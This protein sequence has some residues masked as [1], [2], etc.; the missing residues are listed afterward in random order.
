[1]VPHRHQNWLHVSSTRRS[2]PIAVSLIHQP[3]LW[4]LS[5]DSPH[6]KVFQFYVLIWKAYISF[7]QYI[8]RE[9]VFKLLE[10]LGDLKLFHGLQ[11]SECS[12]LFF[13]PIS[14]QGFGLY[15]NLD[16]TSCLQGFPTRPSSAQ[17]PFS[18]SQSS[19]LL[20]RSQSTGHFL[21]L[22]KDLWLHIIIQKHV[23]C[24]EAGIF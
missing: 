24:Y 23:V 5:H 22:D 8:I 16:I 10:P 11:S 17:N 3:Q 6:Y 1:M 13:F 9:N 15:S 12:G 4:V 7:Y 21:G 19:Y 20:L 14:L 18:P 2:S